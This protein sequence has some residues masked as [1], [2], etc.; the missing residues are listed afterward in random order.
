MILLADVFLEIPPPRIM[1]RSMSKKPSFRGA[2]DRQQGKWVKTL[3]QSE[4]KHLYNIF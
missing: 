1:V 3:L 4:W 2:L